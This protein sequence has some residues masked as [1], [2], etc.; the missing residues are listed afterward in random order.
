MSH[1]TAIRPAPDEFLPYYGKY[2]ALVPEDQA[3]PALE[4]QAESMFAFLRSLSDEQGSLRYQPGKWSVK[5]IIGHVTDAERVFSYRALRFGRGDLTPL[6]GF[7]ENHYAENAGSDQQPL[8][9][10]IDHLEQVRGATLALFRSLTSEAWT[11]RGEANG[12]PVT[13]RALAFIIA[14][15]GH[16]H[17]G[18][19]KERYLG[20]GSISAAR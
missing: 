7:D 15:H 18:V 16:H 9:Q 10:L 14:G 6:S 2:L 20:T 3:M 1:P 12:A 19:I 11:R 5:Q 17:M 13:V 4:R 8:S